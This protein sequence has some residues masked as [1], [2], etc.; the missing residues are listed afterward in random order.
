MRAAKE[1]N[2]IL[3]AMS[4]PVG[5]DERDRLVD[6]VTTCL[7]SKVISQN[8]DALAPL[9]VDAVLSVV[10]DAAGAT[11]V[12]L[13]KIRVVKQVARRRGEA[14]RLWGM[15]VE[16]SASRAPPE[17]G[18][19]SSRSPRARGDPGFRRPGPGKAV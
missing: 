15:A 2:A 7:S 19:P 6:A 12:D 16:A 10:G 5:L 13:K 11:T 18:I 3:E 8:S 14:G 4:V 1:C 9:A 17:R